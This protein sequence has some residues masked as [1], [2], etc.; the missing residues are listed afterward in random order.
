MTIKHIIIP[1]EKSDITDSGT[2]KGYGSTFG[3]KPDSYGDI[4]AHGAFTESIAKNGRGGMGI[5]MLSQHN[6]DE[7][8]G[9]YTHMSQD[10]KGLYLEG[11]FVM[12]VQKARETHALMK[13]GALKGL[14]IG[15]DLFRNSDGKVAEDAREISKD[16]KTALLKRIDLWE[17]SPVTFAANTR[18]RVTGVKSFENA[19]TVRELEKL[20][21]DSGLAKSEA[22]Y[23]ASMC[24]S[25][26][27]DS[28]TDEVE[29]ILN[30]LNSTINN[31]QVD[32]MLD[33]LKTVNNTIRSF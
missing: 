25:G 27:R 7:P 31:I 8:I 29:D 20:L 12:E 11:Q 26:L 23:I 32:P 18:A 13:A 5:A 3:G 21:R 10:K 22:V 15:F 1:F 14:S 30:T 33:I 4:I 6:H 9:V 28:G 19:K 16:G 17:V 24:K 2:F